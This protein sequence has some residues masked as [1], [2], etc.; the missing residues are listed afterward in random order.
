MS[1]SMRKR[2]QRR[3]A[4]AIQKGR[5]VSPV[6]AT[7]IL[8]LIAVAAAAAL[9]LWLVSWQGSVTG[10]IGTTGP[11]ATVTIGGS[12]SVYPFEQAA[13]T[14]FQQNQT[15]IAIS[16]NQGGTGAGMLAV[17]HGSVDIGAASTYQTLTGLETA[18]QCPATTVINT[19][20]WDA[21]DVIV[22]TAN[23]HAL[24]SISWDTLT[25]VYAHASST[26]AT[27]V[28]PSI[29]G[30]LVTTAPLTLLPAGALAW[31][32]IPACSAGVANCGG[33]GNPTEALAGAAVFGAGAACATGNDIC[34]A[35][36]PTAS[37]CG[38]TVCAGGTLAV[39]GT[40]AIKV[41]ARSDASGTTQTLEARLFGAT[42]ATAFATTTAGLGFGGCGSNNILADCGMTIA[43][44]G[45]GNPGVI[46]AVGGS[47]DALGYASDG[48]A[49]ATGSGVL[50]LPFN[51][52]G[53]SA[54]VNPS[55]GTTGS[56][57]YGAQ[58]IQGAT[59][60][61]SQVPYAGV[62]PFQWVTTTAPSGEVEQLLTWVLDPANNLNVAADT[63]EVSVYSI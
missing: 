17:C 1:G 40:D 55:L 24:S 48:L 16:V 28:A 56:I 9:Y 54:P 10:T 5:A 19:I 58:L 45:N 4:R 43:T 47:A 23:S 33:A 30:V 21:V 59:L 60:T 18:D 49:R 11:Q 22:P 26:P 42:S 50:F 8:I 2:I 13:V 39:P 31:D 36:A 20:A 53:Q 35:G 46:T 52:V 15:D 63:G 27:L 38:F 44:T 29:D 34:A 41:V 3:R 6:V 14:Q 7:L 37:P 57:S 51:G 12:T 62:R 61:V 25:A 32:Q